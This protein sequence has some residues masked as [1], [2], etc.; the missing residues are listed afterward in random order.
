MLKR[1]V[2][3]L[4]LLSPLTALYA[5]P[6]GLSAR[7]SEASGT[8]SRLYPARL[9]VMID[10]RGFFFTNSTL[11]VNARGQPGYYSSLAT[12]QSVHYYYTLDDARRFV[13]TQIHILP[14]GTDVSR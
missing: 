13:L 4:L 5:E 3:A 6:A 14:E 1:L 11:V 9:G 10:D 2:L 8:I 7:G 12:G